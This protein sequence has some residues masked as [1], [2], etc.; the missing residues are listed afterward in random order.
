MALIYEI[1]RS[2]PNDGLGN[3]LY[4]QAGII[5]DNFAEINDKKVEKVD[6]WGLSENDYT[7]EEVE[8]LFGIEW[9][10]QVNVKPNWEQNDPSEPDYILNRPT[11]NDGTIFI[12]DGKAGTTSGISA[13]QTTFTLPTS[14][15]IAKSVHVND[16]FYSP[17]TANNTDRVNRWS[18]SG[19]VV[20]IYKALALNNYILI[21]YV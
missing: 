18:Q 2:T 1:N 3:T 14:T 19:A 17:T 21:E 9:G 13:G 6:G 16:A 5:N 15:A 4:D 20:T 7:D 11:I 10:A 12:L 8:K